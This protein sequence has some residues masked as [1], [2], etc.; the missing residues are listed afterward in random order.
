MPDGGDPNRHPG[1]VDRFTPSDDDFFPRDSVIRRVNAEPGIMFGAGR[2]L[3]LQV[4]HPAVAQGVAD[5]SDFRRDPF[6]RLQGTLTALNAIV[7]GSTALAIEVG[8]RVQQLHEHIIG[9]SYRA[10]DVE[11]LL[12]VHATLCDSALDAQRRFVGGLSDDDIVTYYEQMKRVGEVFGVPRAVLPRTWLD[13]RVYF[14][15]MVESLEVTDVGRAL[16]SDIVQPPLPA[17]VGLAVTPLTALHHL[18][19]IGTTPEPLRQQFGFTW[20]SHHQHVLATIETMSRVTCTVV[21]RPL[22]VL[23]TTLGALVFFSRR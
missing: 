4:A 6:R 15:A 2:A 13:F 10:N 14:D 5:H 21:P 8:R 20:T 3:L 19:A 22:R 9:A 11:N 1:V 18:I 12:W 7:Y 16:A 17:L 23:P